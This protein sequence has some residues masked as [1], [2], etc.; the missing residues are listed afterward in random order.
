MGSTDGPGEPARSG[1]P[2]PTISEVLVRFLEDRCRARQPVTIDRYLRID[3][4]L[5]TYLEARGQDRLC[6]DDALLLAAEREFQPLGAFCR[7]MHADALLAALPD[8][9]GA[10]WLMPQGLD[11]KVQIS[12]SSRLVHWLIRGRVVDFRRQQPDLVRFR[13]MLDG[14]QHRPPC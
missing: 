6:S 7:I 4:H 5:R 12:Q 14:L 11:R 9:L 1:V 10:D 8:F 13:T 3:E 2:G